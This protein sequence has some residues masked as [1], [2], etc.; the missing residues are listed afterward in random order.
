MRASLQELPDPCEGKILGYLDSGHKILCVMGPTVDIIDPSRPVICAPD[1][2]SDGHWVWTA[3][4]A[5]Y[6]RRYHLK[7]PAEFSGQMESNNWIVPPAGDLDEL[8][9]DII[10]FL[11]L[12]S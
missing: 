9:R 1:V 8:T 5:Y 7:L 6:V 11:R 3:D 4:V 10:Q 2:L 12:K